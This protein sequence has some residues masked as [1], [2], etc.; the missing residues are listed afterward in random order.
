MEDIKCLMRQY[1]AGA[2]AA[3]MLVTGGMN[4]IN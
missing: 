1:I 4:R 3:A 2:E